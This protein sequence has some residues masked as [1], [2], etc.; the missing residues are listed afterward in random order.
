MSW[1][2]AKIPCP[3]RNLSPLPNGASPPGGNAVLLTNVPLVE[4]ASRTHG[5]PAPLTPITA[6]LRD[7]VSSRDRKSACG[8]TSGSRPS[9]TCAP[10]CTSTWQCWSEPMADD[11]NV[12]LSVRACAGGALAAPRIGAAPPSVATAPNG[13]VAPNGTAPAL[14][15]APSAVCVIGPTPVTAVT[16]ESGVGTAGAKMKSAKPQS[17]QI[18]SSS[19]GKRPQ[20][21][22]CRTICSAPSPVVLIEARSPL[23]RGRGRGPPSVRRPPNR[24]RTARGR[25]G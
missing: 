8:D 4:Y 2:L 10:G 7:T 23:D 15:A 20:L 13:A 12:A 17:S 1:I 21:R 24:G 11:R 9:R 6:C 5:E 14:G 22:H 3:R 19:A 18:T 16:T 25:A